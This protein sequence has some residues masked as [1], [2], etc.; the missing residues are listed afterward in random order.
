MLSFHW[1]NAYDFQQEDIT[2][3]AV[4]ARDYAMTDVVDSYEGVWP[5]MKTAQ[6]APGKY[7]LKVT[8]ED[9]QGNQQT[10]FDYY[11]AENGKVYGVYCFYALEDGS[12]EVDVYE[13]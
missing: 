6:V 13:E 8:A 2:Y 10:A 9:T 4:L 12:I 1:D 7:F 11:V 5:E 3:Q